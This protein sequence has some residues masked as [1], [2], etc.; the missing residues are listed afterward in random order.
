[1]RKSLLTRLFSSVKLFFFLLIAIFAFGLLSFFIQLLVVKIQPTPQFKSHS[2]L[3][4][5]FKETIKFKIGYNHS[6][7]VDYNYE[8]CKY[9]AD[10]HVE[11]KD[12]RRIKYFISIYGY[13]PLLYSQYRADSVLFKTR[14]PLNKQ[15]CFKLI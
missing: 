1:M 2:N 15:K 5:N 6:K 10:K 3:L 8:K 14:L 4:Y 12:L 11:L 7:A 13:N 9:L